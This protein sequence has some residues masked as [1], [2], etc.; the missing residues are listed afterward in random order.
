MEY[1]S[2]KDASAYLVLANK[3]NALGENYS[4]SDLVSLQNDLGIP[5]KNKSLEL[6]ESAAYA[7]KAMLSAMVAD[8]V[9]GAYLSD[10]EKPND[11]LFVTSAYRSYE[12]QEKLYNGYVSQYV[13]EGMSE[14]EAM[15]EA[16]RTSARPG[17]S[18]HQTGLCFDFIT[19]SMGG[20][21][22]KRFENAPAFTWLKSNAHLYGFILRYP[23]GDDKIDITG[24]DY[25][26]WHYRFVGREAAVE[27]YNSGLTLEEYLD[28]N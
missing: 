6:C 13:T 18:E 24:Y 19:E 22:D 20:N 1:I 26:P 5:S 9:D 16:S 3:E 23:N 8:G 12:Y 25:E 7:L 27:I 14:E 28:L 2:P 21:L 15:A 10:N 4:P 17:E 11:A